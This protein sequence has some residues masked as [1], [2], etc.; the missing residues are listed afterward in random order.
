M[1]KPLLFIA[2]T[3]ITCQSV[4]SLE[5]PLKRERGLFFSLPQR[6]H[7]RTILKSRINFM[8]SL[9]ELKTENITREVA[10]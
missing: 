8:V 2:Q 9:H 7:A 4:D 6:L 5:F 10:Y 3:P 1:Q